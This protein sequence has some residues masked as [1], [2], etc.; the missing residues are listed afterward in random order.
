KGLIQG[1]VV[2]L[3]NA[4]AAILAEAGGRQFHKGRYAR[5]SDY[6]RAT[7]SLRQPGSAW[8]PLV[9]LAAF[10]QDMNLDSMV[11]D[12][13]IGIPAE[14]D[15]RLKWIANYD[16]KFKGPITLRDAL[17]QS[18]NV[19][20]VKLAERVGISNVI[21][22]AHRLGITSPLAKNLSLALG[23][24]EVS[25]FELAS[26]YAV[27]ASEGKRIRPVFVR[28]ILDRHGQIIGVNKRVP[29]PNEGA[30]P[31]VKSTYEDKLELRRAAVGPEDFPPGNVMSRS[32]AYQITDLLQGVVRYGTGRSVQA[33]GRPAAGKTGTT[34]DLRDAWFIGFTPQLVAGAWVGFDEEQPIGHKETGGRAAAPIWLYFME[35]A[36]EGKPVLDFQV[37]DTITFA[38]VDS[39]TGRPAGE[40]ERGNTIFEAFKQ[41]HEPPVRRNDEGSEGASYTAG[42]LRPPPVDFFRRDYQ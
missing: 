18:R 41:G 28:K 14:T 25:L 5:Y 8:K 31:K 21:L 22:T 20:T 40:D 42:P 33:L 1:S 37:P 10:R 26:A 7:G 36:L 15:R 11:P 13:P 19:P 35:K 34:N 12:E 39:H 24:G 27:F 16:N 23:A 2:V 30:E 32:T 17:A 38:R 4:D 9:Y 6:N 29:D 3:R